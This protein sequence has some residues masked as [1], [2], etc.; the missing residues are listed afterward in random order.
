MAPGLELGAHLAVIVDL[1]IVADREAAFLGQH[2]LRGRVRKVD[3]REATVS[4]AD[5]RPCPDP[6]AVRSAM[7]EYFGHRRDSR[8]IDRL[9]NVRMEQA[10]DAAHG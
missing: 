4:E 7:G 8:R 1:A 2:R 10:G 9:G 5:T 3:D 6:A